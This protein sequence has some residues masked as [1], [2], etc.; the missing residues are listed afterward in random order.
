MPTPSQWLQSW[1]ESGA[2][3]RL[4][5]GELL[6]ATNGTEG[7]PEARFYAPDFFLLDAQPWHPFSSTRI[8]TIEALVPLLNGL[9][10]G[11]PSAWQVADRA[12]FERDFSELQDEFKARRLEK[13]VPIIFQTTPAQVSAGDRA[14]WIGSALRFAAAR[15]VTVYGL[16]DR[17]SGMVGATPETLF[18]LSP[19]SLKT[20]ALA[21]TRRNGEQDRQM[22]LLDDPKE[23]REHQLVID[24]IRGQLSPFGTLEIGETHVQDLGALSHLKT[25][26]GLKST[27]TLE[28]SRMIETMHPTPALGGAPRELARAWLKRC[29]ERAQVKRKRFGAPFGVEFGSQ[30]CAVVAIR[31]LQWDSSRLY[32][33][34][35]CGV[36]AE[37]EVTREWAELQGKIAS[38][39]TI[40]GETQQ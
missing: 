27:A 37:S 5:S 24:W 31:N 36:I 10:S 8:F 11:T 19:G 28:F 9:S 32:L 14:R 16:W 6:L 1:L 2:I 29:D 23:R 33:G 35:G 12:G 34:A 18:R 7:G 4:P 15:P 3:F 40:F 30:S 13:A 21:G 38:V 25:E 20:M 26:I 39:K 17:S 22:A